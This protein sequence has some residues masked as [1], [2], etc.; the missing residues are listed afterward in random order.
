MTALDGTGLQVLHLQN[1]F[2]DFRNIEDDLEMDVEKISPFQNLIK[3]QVLN[4][5]NNSIKT[6]LHDW[7]TVNVALTELDLSHNQIEMINFGSIFNIWIDNIR[8]NVSHNQ[9]TKMFTS[10]HIAF[11]PNQSNVIWILNHN[12]LRCDC[13][14]IHFAMQLRKQINGLQNAT[15]IFITDELKCLE[16]ERFVNQQ[17]QNV[18]LAQLT[19]PLDKKNVSAKKCPT[20][21]EC[22][23]RTID[24]T[25]IFN[26]SNAHLTKIPALPDI[27]SLGLQHYELHIENNNIS[28]L[29][30]ANTTGY[31]S[32]NRIYAKNNTLEII[33]PEHLPNDL[34]DLDLSAN[35]LKRINP[36][37]L[38][39]L[40]HMQNLQ[41]V[42]FSWNPWICDCVAYQLMNFIQ[43]H[44]TKIVGINEI[45]CD[46]DKSQTLIS[47]NG[48]CPI[49]ITTI[50][51]LLIAGIFA[52]MLFTTIVYYKNQQE[53]MVWIFAHHAFSW[54]FNDKTKSNDTTKKYDVFVLCSMLDEDFVIGNVLPQLENG[55]NALKVCSNVREIKSGAD[56]PKQVM[57]LKS[58]EFPENSEKININ[59]SRFSK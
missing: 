12:P 44:F 59:L 9:I 41:N 37:V 2:L 53:I 28:T 8:I 56:V 22:F 18:P 13:V 43:T 35:K 58:I 42:S 33:L 34:Y 54:L 24:H 11:N 20:K 51:M 39:K 5:R 50:F 29:S 40:S 55:R 17:L 1:N 4:M 27:Q 25:A 48:L 57:L 26:C 36:D 14:V 46:N 47:Q 38:L 31:K 3:L 52:L 7:H 16:P 32:V 21:C 6:F 10:K 49:D 45:T 19:C 30:M 15:T 23:V